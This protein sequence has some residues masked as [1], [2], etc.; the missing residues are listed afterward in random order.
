MDHMWKMK[1]DP[2][3]RKKHEKH[4]RE[5]CKWLGETEWMVDAAREINELG[6]SCR[7]GTD[8][9]DRGRKRRTD[10]VESGPKLRVVGISDIA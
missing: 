6:A 2:V 7:K 5:L 9:V 3:Y 8:G 10:G 1:R 4:I